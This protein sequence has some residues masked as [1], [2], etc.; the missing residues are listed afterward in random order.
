M[1]DRQD[2]IDC[3][4]TYL[5][6]RFQHQARLKSVAVDCI[7]LIVGV[8]LELGFP[9]ADHT[10]Y[11][12]V[13]NGRDLMRRLRE[14]F[15]EIPIDNGQPGDIAVFKIKVHP[16]HVGILTPVGII[17]TNAMVGKVVEHSIDEELRGNIV[18]MFRFR[19]L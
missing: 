2:I 13:P 19:G 1:P 5:G 18:S 17:H 4:R 8:G 11:G 14:Q 15:D 9:L 16:Q 7:G 3:A 6:T 10:Q 12:R